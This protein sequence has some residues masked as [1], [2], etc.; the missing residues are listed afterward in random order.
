MVSGTPLNPHSLTVREANQLVEMVLE[1]AGVDLRRADFTGR[2]LKF[3]EDIPGFE[4]MQ[5]AR[6][7]R[8]VHQLWSLYMSKKTKPDSATDTTGST[9]ESNATESVDLSSPA[10]QKAIAEGRALIEQG[11][12]KADAA[13]VI[14]SAIRMEPKEVI[15]AAFVEG[16]TLTPKGAL[17]YWYNNRRKAAKEGKD[18]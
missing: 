10:I 11:Q 13:R 14:F 8:I 16:A 4:T 12:S 18:A 1:S 15:V 2:V 7:D 6:A 3:F 5:P 9:P 17:T